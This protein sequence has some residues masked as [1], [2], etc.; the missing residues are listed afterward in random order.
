MLSSHF[1]KKKLSI[2]FSSESPKLS[3]LSPKDPTYFPDLKSRVG[4]H[5]KLLGLS[6]G[7]YLDGNAHCLDFR[8][9]THAR[10]TAQIGTGPISFC[11]E[12]GLHLPAQPYENSRYTWRHPTLPL[13]A[14]FRN[15]EEGAV[16]FF[17]TPDASLEELQLLFPDFLSGSE[18]NFTRNREGFKSARIKTH[19][20]STFLSILPEV[21]NYASS[22]DAD[23]DAESDQSEHFSETSY[24]ANLL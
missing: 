22:S 7:C 11:K 17:V 23:S 4:I 13:R 9:P 15:V 8:L 21:P 12:P 18:K 20:T 5:A 16:D 24:L 1:F 10:T 14:C 19:P 3:L 6:K 2:T